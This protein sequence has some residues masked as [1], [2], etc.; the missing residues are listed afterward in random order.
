MKRFPSKEPGT[1]TINR[2]ATYVHINIDVLIGFGYARPE[3]ENEIS[4]SS[5]FFV[6]LRQDGYIWIRKKSF[7][8]FAFPRLMYVQYTIVQVQNTYFLL[9]Y[10]S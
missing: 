6:G 8:F 1:T 2:A 4:S 10:I 9:L 7:F 5:F 3:L